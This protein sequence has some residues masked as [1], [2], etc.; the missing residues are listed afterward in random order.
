MPLMSDITVDA[1]KFHPN[2]ISEQT[3]KVNN[4]LIKLV[5]GTPTWFEVRITPAQ[6]L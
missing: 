5:E 1:A 6:V 4:H 2:A 3:I